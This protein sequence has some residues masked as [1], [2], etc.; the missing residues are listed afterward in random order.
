[1]HA[2]HVDMPAVAAKVPIGQDEQTV[3]EAA[4]YL[5]AAHDPVTTESPVVPQ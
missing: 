2:E 1:V 3:A 5:P 4:E